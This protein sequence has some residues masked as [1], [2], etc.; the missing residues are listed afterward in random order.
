MKKKETNFGSFKRKI[1]NSFSISKSSD[2]FQSIIDHSSSHNTILQQQQ[3]QQRC[4]KCGHLLEV[5]L[6]RDKLL[7]FPE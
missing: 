4:D 3:Q 6:A 5:L 7:M 2:V 1:T